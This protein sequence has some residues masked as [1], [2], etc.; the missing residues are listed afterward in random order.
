[1]ETRPKILGPKCT[2]FP[3]ILGIFF[4]KKTKKRKPNVY[5]FFVEK[6]TKKI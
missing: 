2:F 5:L 3:Y 4:Q 6:T 1:M